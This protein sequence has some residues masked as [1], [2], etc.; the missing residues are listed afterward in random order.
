MVP[1][2]APYDH[3]VWPPFKPCT[4]PIQ[5]PLQ[6]HTGAP[7]KREPSVIEK[8]AR[9]RNDQHNEMSSMVPRSAP[10]NHPIQPLFKPLMAPF[11]TPIQDPH[12]KDSF[13]V[14]HH[15]IHQ[16]VQL[17]KQRKMHPVRPSEHS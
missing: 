10:Y 8:R 2:S 7:F 3:P 5:R 17:N 12:S 13:P 15:K 16:S 4:G 1:R 14:Q 9:Y 11:R 6:P